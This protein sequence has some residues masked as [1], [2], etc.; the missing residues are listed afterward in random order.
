M[1]FARDDGSYKGVINNLFSFCKVSFPYRYTIVLPWQ[2]H[3]MLF[4][5]YIVLAIIRRHCLNL[6]RLYTIRCLRRE[7]NTI[8]VFHGE[9]IGVTKSP[10]QWQKLRRGRSMV[11]IKP[12]CMQSCW[13]RAHLL[14]CR[15]TSARQLGNAAA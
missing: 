9:A 11:K 12:S 13:Y 15:F 14:Q 6:R 8:I 1:Q 2:L 7:A 3:N 5:Y 4:Y 10:W